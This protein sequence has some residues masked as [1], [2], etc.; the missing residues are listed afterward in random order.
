MGT[1]LSPADSAAHVLAAYGDH[2]ASVDP[3]DAA[4]GIT[5]RANARA[6]VIPGENQVEHQIG[7]HSVKRRV[8]V[9]VED[10]RIIASEAVLLYPTV[11]KAAARRDDVSS[12]DRDASGGA[13]AAAADARAGFGRNG[14]HPAAVDG[15]AAVSGCAAA[16]IETNLR[17]AAADARAVNAG[18]RHAGVFAA[19]PDN[20]ATFAVCAFSGGRAARADT[21]SAAVAYRVDNAAGNA[22][23]RSLLCVQSRADSSRA[24]GVGQTTLRR[25]IGSGYLPSADGN[26]AI[27]T[28]RA[29]DARAAVTAL[30]NDRAAGNRHIRPIA[31]DTRACSP[32]GNLSA[33]A[34]GVYFGNFPFITVF[35]A[36]LDVDRASVDRDG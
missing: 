20:G 8:G 1:A 31:A 26:Q 21:R 32:H 27:G 12:V 28:G 6:G 19:D 34:E 5:A 11:F 10:G 35:H 7:N 18:G 17:A 36:A 15:D 4:A 2:G 9:V 30:G 25:C 13:L 29:A 14:A 16:V 24:I 3:D 22:D 33:V 23:L